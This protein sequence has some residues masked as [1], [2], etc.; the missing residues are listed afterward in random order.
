MSLEA[1][2][3]LFEQ[4]IQ[5]LATRTQKTRNPILKIFKKSRKPGPQMQVGAV[6]RPRNCRFGS[7][8]VAPSTPSDGSGD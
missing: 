8:E 2:L 4:S 1:L 5:G 3:T 7:G 6:T